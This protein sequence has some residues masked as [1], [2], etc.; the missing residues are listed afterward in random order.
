MSDAPTPA[1]PV[2]AKRPYKRR[3]RIEDGASNPSEAAVEAAVEAVPEPAAVAAEASSDPV[4]EPEITEAQVKRP[5]QRTR[6]TR[7]ASHP[8]APSEEHAEHYRQ[9]SDAILRQR[10]A[11]AISHDLAPS[12]KGETVAKLRAQCVMALE[13]YDSTVRG[14]FTGF[15]RI[16]PS[17]INDVNVLREYLKQIKKQTVL[18]RDGAKAFNNMQMLAK[19]Y[20]TLNEAVP[21]SRMFFDARG[22]PKVLDRNR[23]AYVQDL[24]ELAQDYPEIT[25]MQGPEVRL[26][27]RLIEDLAATHAANKVLEMKREMQKK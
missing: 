8:E 26:S 12:N 20:S 4:P 9:Q 17:D 7:G 22:L 5:R 16:D 18:G 25:M 2:R 11:E 19:G 27:A 15:V 3:V 14:N 1:E 24:G 21:L 10:Q 23:E 6:V 13:Q